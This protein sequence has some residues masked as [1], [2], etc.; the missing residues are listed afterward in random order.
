MDLKAE[1]EDKPK[2][3]YANA[4]GEED[5]SYLTFTDAIRYIKEGHIGVSSFMNDIYFNTEHPEN[6][7]IRKFD[8]D[9]DELPIFYYDGET[10]KE[11]ISAHII[12]I[13]FIEYKAFL[14]HML[15]T[16]YAILPEEVRE[17][18]LTQ[19][20]YDFFME[21][22]GDMLGIQPNI[23][24]HKKWMEKHVPDTEH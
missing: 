3:H 2:K 24:L 21:E 14:T 16:K 12:T 1:E 5:K 8:D 4:Y 15:N 10:W 6:H 20:D 22:I 9:E 17:M 18:I 19:K 13:L 11:S 7:C 23:T